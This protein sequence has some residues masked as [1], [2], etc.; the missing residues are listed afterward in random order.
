MMIEKNLTTREL[1]NKYVTKDI[2]WSLK[3]TLSSGEL[4]LWLLKYFIWFGKKEVQVN[5][6]KM[7]KRT[8]RALGRSPEEKIKGHSGV[9]YR[10]PLMLYTKYQGT[11]RFLQ[12][13]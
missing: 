1:T 13:D 5:H 11:S 3:L 10:G 6:P 4:K 2:Q 7:N 8:Q 12:D 9:I